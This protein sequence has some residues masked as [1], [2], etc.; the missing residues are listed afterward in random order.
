[1]QI[2]I[3]GIFLRN[4]LALLTTASLAGC[5]LLIGSIS[6]FKINYKSAS[7]LTLTNPIEVAPFTME[8]RAGINQNI[9]VY[10][11]GKFNNSELL[12]IETSLKNTLEQFKQQQSE[13]PYVVH[14]HFQKYILVYSNSR[15]S[16]LA[17]ADWC[18]ER[19]GKIL[20]N[21][22]TYAAFDRGS[23]PPATLGS[24]KTHINKAIVTRIIERTLV[25]ASPGYQEQPVKLIYPDLQSALAI[26][27]SGVGLNPGSKGMARVLAIA[28]SSKEYGGNAAYS[29]ES[30]VTPI[31]WKTRLKNY[32]GN[33][34]GNQTAP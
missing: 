12:K 5:G 24:A 8:E 28:I 29:S 1:M 6:D 11:V 27:P 18:L 33:K 21:E 7:Q 31:D 9:G 16:V 10:N 2:S 34:P 14:V 13:I 22:I 25:V 23:F 20:H 4:I 17:L 19:E 26:L 30:A 3:S 15:V 32:Y